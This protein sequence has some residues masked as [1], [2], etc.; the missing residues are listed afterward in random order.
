MESKKLIQVCE[1][2]CFSPMSMSG[3][4]F[5]FFSDV[6]SAEVVDSAKKSFQYQCAD[7]SGTSAKRFMDNEFKFASNLRRT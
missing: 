1:H 4:D 7:G 6:N 3:A 5:N 2:A